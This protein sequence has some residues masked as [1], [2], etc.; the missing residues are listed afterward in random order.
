MVDNY[1]NVV[2]IK[3]L[4]RTVTNA[5]SIVRILLEVYVIVFREII[6]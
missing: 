2:S 1:D 3:N 4:I 5:K 6:F